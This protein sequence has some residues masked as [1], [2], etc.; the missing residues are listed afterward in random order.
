MQMGGTS[1]DDRLATDLRNAVSGEVL[2]PGDDGY[3]AG[4]TVYFTSVDRR[5][6][7][8]VRPDSAA[9]VASVVTIARESGSGLAVRNGGHSFA[10]HGVRDGGIVL[11]MRSLRSLDIDVKR[12]VARAGAGLST[13]E[14]TAAAGAHGLATGFGDAPSVGISGITLAGGIGFLHRRHG[15]TIDHL[16]GAEVVTADGRI[17]R[18]DAHSHADLYWAIRGGGGGFGVVTQLE[19]RLEPVDH[20]LGGMLIL[21]ATPT[22]LVALLEQ[23]Y[24]AP[25]ALSLI[26]AVMPAPPMPFIP[27][28]AHGSMIMM[29]TLVYAGDV[30]EG[31]RVVA[32]FRSLATPLL[33]EVKPMRYPAI[34]DGHADAPHPA[35]VALHPRF[36]ESLDVDAA[37]ALFEHLKTGSAPMRMAQFRPLGGAVARV[38]SD[39]TAFAHRDRRIIAS[40]G[41]MYERPEQHAEYAAW[42]AAGAAGL[43][44]DAPGAY[45]GFLGEEG[46][47]RVDE[48]Y[49]GETGARLARIRREYDPTNLFA[50]KS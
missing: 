39:A 6:D 8:I 18:A 1:V 49:P 2:T 36:I 13:G 37:A 42:A 30:A 15:M 50:G 44:D 7:V 41:A 16:L 28:E 25:D 21:P 32:E 3:D 22:S 24:A 43:G 20:V 47:A 9:D 27:A 12:R 38:S 10:G 14:Y 11:D 35:A 5:P 31:Q 23:A 17:V 33:D 26:V 46:A 40:V 29:V 34:Y 19:F 4:R 48:A 45:V